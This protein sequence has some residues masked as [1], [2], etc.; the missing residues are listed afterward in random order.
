MS[1]CAAARSSLCRPKLLSPSA[2]VPRRHFSRRRTSLRRPSDSSLPRDPRAGES[3]QYRIP[4]WRWRWFREHTNDNLFWPLLVRLRLVCGQYCYADSMLQ[5]GDSNKARK[6]PPRRN[7]GF[8]GAKH[9][10]LIL[11]QERTS[12]VQNGTL[13]HEPLRPG[14]DTLRTHLIGVFKITGCFGLPYLIKSSCPITSIEGIHCR[15]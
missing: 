9:A 6:C 8:C 14:Q 4:A 1:Q 10:S 12:T 11:Y 15:K 7:S 13:K 2:S 3:S 5:N